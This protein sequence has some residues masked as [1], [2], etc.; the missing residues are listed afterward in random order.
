V[1]VL[2]GAE[3]GTWRD[4]E[5]GEALAAGRAK[6][7]IPVLAPGVSFSE[8][9]ARLR[10]L[11]AI[12]LQPDLARQLNRLCDAV[13]TFLQAKPHEPVV[14][15]ADPDDPQKGR[16]GGRS[17]RNGRV[18]AATVESITSEWFEVGLSVTGTADRPLTGVVE[19]HL[20]PSFL[21]AVETVKVK[22]NTA[23]LALRAWGA[24]TVGA[25]AD[26]GATMLE[27][28]L[29]EQEEFPRTFRER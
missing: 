1:V 15:A 29:A 21:H 18:L 7:V 22:G 20:H 5:I 25:I 13:E 16:W 14:G 23:T 9:P 4:I 27:L 11:V 26:Q 12:D 3:G 17:E 19:F 10:E 6:R 28:D 2:V 8:V 24:F